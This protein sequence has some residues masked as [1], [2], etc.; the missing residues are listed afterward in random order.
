M[1]GAARR[2]WPR[3]GRAVD[4]CERPSCAPAGLCPGQM[5]F[6]TSCSTAGPSLWSNCS[7]RPSTPP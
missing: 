2:A 3:R 7:D 4:S 1:A 6:L 5:G